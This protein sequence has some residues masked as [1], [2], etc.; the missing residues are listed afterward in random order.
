M[1]N[2]N[3]LFRKGRLM[4]AAIGF[5]SVF[6]GANAQNVFV[7]PQTGK[8]IVALT[9]SQEV[10][11]EN[12]WNSF[13]KHDQLPLTITV[14]DDANLTDAGDLS[15]PAANINVSQNGEGLI[16]MGGQPYDSYMAVTLPK[17]YRFTGYSITLQNNMDGKSYAN[18]DFV[19]M[20]KVF[21]ETNDQFSKSS[22]KA[23]AR[24][25]AGDNKEYTIERQS[26]G[27]LDMGN[28][29]YFL[30]ERSSDDFYGV[31][32]KS[33]EIFFTTDGFSETMSP[34]NALGNVSFCQTPFFI[35]KLDLGEIKKNTKNNKTY[36]SYNYQNVKD[37]VAYNLLYQDDA[38]QNGVA[39]DYASTK[40]ISSLSVNGQN[41]FALGNDT[42][43][44]ESPMNVTLQDGKTVLPV[45]YRITGAKLKMLNP[46]PNTIFVNKNGTVYYLNSEL[47]FTTTPVEWILEG[48]KLKCGGKYLNIKRDGFVNP[49]YNLVMSTS[50]GDGVTFEV[51]NGSVFGK[52]NGT[53]YDS[54]GYISM[55]SDGKAVLNRSVT[56]SAA[57][58]CEKVRMSSDYTLKLFGT[59][60]DN[61]VK[62]VAVNASS[63]EQTVE[64]NNLNNDAVKF[65]VEGLQEN[66]KAIVQVE[67]TMEYLNPYVSSLDVVCKEKSG[68]QSV[69]QTQ[70]VNN[71]EVRGGE[72][73]FYVPDGGGAECS[74][75]FENL[76]S[77]YADNT[78]YN[79]E[80]NGTSRY[81][82]VNSEY[83]TSGKG[84][85]L[86]EGYDPN[87]A[88]NTKVSTTLAGTV[89]F[90]FSNI[91]ELNNT[92]TS[93]DVRQL[94][95]YPFSIEA[96]KAQT[97]PGAG[98][99][100]T[101][102]LSVG[103]KGTAY[104]FVADEPRYNI[105]PTTGIEHRYFA[106]YKMSVEL[107]RG[108]YE[109]KVDLIKIYDSTCYDGDET[110]A[111]Y[112][113]KVTTVNDQRAEVAG[114]LS[115]E[116]IWSSLKQSMT[117][118][119]VASNQV[120]Y[121]DLSGLN[122]VVATDR[123]TFENLRDGLSSNTLVY[124]PKG[125]NAGTYNY[126]S[127]LQDGS[128]FY[129]GNNMKITDKQPFFA[130]YGI[131]VPAEQYVEYARKITT[132][133]NGKVAT[134][135]VMLPFTISIDDK[136][137]HTNADGTS[138]SVW[139][140]QKDNFISTSAPD[141]NPMNYKS[142]VH[143]VAYT[144][145]TGKTEADVPYMVKV[146]NGTDQTETSFV[147]KQ[148][149]SNIE[150]TKTG[151][152]YTGDTSTGKL[153]GSAFTFTPKASY[154][155]LKLEKTAGN[156]F[157]FGKNMFLNSKNISGDYLYCYP[158]RA[159]YEYGGNTS[160]RAF[161]VTFG[162]NFGDVTGIETAKAAETDVEVAP[163]AGCIEIHA[164]KNAAV[165][166]YD[167]SGMVVERLDMIAGDTQTVNLPA[168]I[169]LVNKNKVAVK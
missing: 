155:G 40:N 77:N 88:Y 48:K 169:Y 157:Y 149:G 156:Y 1:Q 128:V 7:S 62:T 121:V 25:N 148:Y 10:G 122:N 110:V 85:K 73:K 119:N 97:K 163:G 134:A 80:G 164:L 29:L 104:L 101:F 113:A 130:P 42:Y 5:L 160:A 136:G 99:F 96:Y 166:V 61:V 54:E 93:G 8:L 162:E 16:L 43:Y 51:K 76:K 38:V 36:Y 108:A 131:T 150:A 120:L 58:Y 82:F 154:A 135:T 72:F 117:E 74:F 83:W 32:I 75:L 46:R 138:L 109:P 27:A 145:S 94:E 26:K 17:G 142:D 33:F 126:A 64:I 71:F 129:S 18:F 124:L 168:G 6:S 158:F 87:A 35:H 49:T 86:Y 159:V 144:S 98:E 84:T 24:I 139:A 141:G 89:P 67:L 20:D 37:V 143:F 151:G 59:D 92:S 103:E 19:S 78:Y 133:E 132:D 31:T 30:L 69:K 52:Y 66:T 21:Y 90:R 56:S 45:G 22:Y 44:A 4:L 79:G 161:N 116:Q 114:S 70:D 3:K 147:I 23:I 105:A 81:N 60:K 140:M 55:S 91:D 106:Y 153:D 50:V 118:N 41:W 57:S 53:V 107:S 167:M 9:S 146:E 39:G 34:S 28:H 125:V 100:K 165:V 123:V 152:L 127:R 2:K 14:A 137:F 47:K 63:G 11:F 12:G 102:E 65:A 68:G 95:E 15:N 115:T 112:G 13:W 111:M